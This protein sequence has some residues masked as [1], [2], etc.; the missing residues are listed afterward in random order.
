MLGVEVVVIDSTIK[1][2]YHRM[3]VGDICFMRDQMN[4]C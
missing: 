2:P 3:C 1:W 4:L